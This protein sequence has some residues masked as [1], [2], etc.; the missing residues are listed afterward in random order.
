MMNDKKIQLNV[1]ESRNERA[2]IK[3]DEAVELTKRVRRDYEKG[4]SKSAIAAKYRLPESTIRRML[5]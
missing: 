2:R 4:Y 3:L 1:S 5:G